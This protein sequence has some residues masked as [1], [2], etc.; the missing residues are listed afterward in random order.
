MSQHVLQL[1]SQSR[2]ARGPQGSLSSHTQCR[3][4]CVAVVNSVA[5]PDGR[6][7]VPT[8][9]VATDRAPHAVL[10]ARSIR[11]QQQLAH[12]SGVNESF[13]DH[14]L[15][16]GPERASF[17][18]VDS[19]ESLSAHSWS[20]GPGHRSVVALWDEVRQEAR[21]L[22][23]R[24]PVLAP[25][26]HA[27]V[28]RHADFAACL[29]SV[30]AGKLGDATLPASQ[31]ALLAASLY[32]ADASLLEAASADLQASVERDPACPGPLQCLLYSKGWQAVQ[33]HRLGH[34]LWAAG[35]RPLALALQ[36]R[37]SGAWGVDVHP[38]ARLGRGVFL[39]HGTGVVIGET[40]VVGDGVSLAHGVTLGG[41]GTGKG[42][43]HPVIG[44][45]ALLGAGASVLGPVT[46]GHCARVGAG[47]VVVA[48]VPAHSLAVGIPARV[49]RRFPVTMEPC[50]SMDQTLDDV[51]DYVI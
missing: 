38:A 50:K 33:A 18:E 41:S 19:T 10:E 37:G 51:L 27:S 35:R 17:D 11:Q 7:G 43:R 21:A 6:H 28:L 12:G 14:V 24:E 44:N 29:A 23:R 26:L 46:V 32:G 36:S 20:P 31:L 16:R 49:I 15:R 45:G 1:Q 5:L 47:S 22:A 2:S 25:A 39:D 40:C 3:M 9:A 48:D 4:S 8:K 42:V 13:W 34:A 30:L